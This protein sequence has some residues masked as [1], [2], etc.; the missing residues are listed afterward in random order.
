MANEASHDTNNVDLANDHVRNCLLHGD[1][2]LPTNSLEGIAK[3]V[4]YKDNFISRR[5]YVHYDDV[6]ATT[7]MTKVRNLI[8]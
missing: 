5:D 6:F 2:N 7:A 1:Q 8:H 4:G 3:P